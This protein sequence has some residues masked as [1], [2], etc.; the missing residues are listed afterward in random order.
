MPQILKVAAAQC[1]TLATAK[2]TLNDM[3]LKTK[4]AAAANVDLILFPEVYSGAILAH[5]LSVPLSE[6]ERQKAW[7]SG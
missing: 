6:D 3:E 4:E 5:A 1:R 2:E 7:N